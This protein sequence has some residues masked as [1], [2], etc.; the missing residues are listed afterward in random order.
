MSLILIAHRI[1]IGAAVGFGVFYTV[2]EA[3]TYRQT[4]DPVHLLI[5]LVAGVV[6]LALAYYLKNLKRFVG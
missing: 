3:R 5:A 6:T 1:L 4:A 2:W